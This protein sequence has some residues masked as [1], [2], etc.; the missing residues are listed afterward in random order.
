MRGHIGNFCPKP[1]TVFDDAGMVCWT[2]RA[3]VEETIIVSCCMKEQTYEYRRNRGTL[4][5][6][7]VPAGAE[8]LTL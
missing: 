3:P 4:P 6:R 1:I 7:E 5:G 2:M 8:L